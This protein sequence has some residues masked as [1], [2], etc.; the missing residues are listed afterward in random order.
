MT[1]KEKATELIEQYRSVLRV[2]SIVGSPAIKT[3][4]RCALISVVEILEELYYTESTKNG[5]I[6]WNEVKQEIEKL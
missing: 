5:T 4:K 2:L 6:F 1:P 3:A